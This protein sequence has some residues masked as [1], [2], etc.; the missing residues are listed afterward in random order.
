[1]AT[2]RSKAFY[3]RVALLLALLAGVCV[4]AVKEL[5][6]RRERVEWNR[7]LDVALI[8][9]EKDPIDPSSVDAF[10]DRAYTLREQM[11]TEM[12]RYKPNAPAPF[13]FTIFGPVPATSTPPHPDSDGFIDLT[14]QAWS[15]W[16]WTSDVDE[17]ANVLTKAFDTRIYLVVRK[18]TSG[19]RTVVDGQ[20][21][22]NGR[23]GTVEVELGPD[24][25]DWSLLVAAH[26]LAHTLGATDRY[27]GQNRKE[28]MSP[29][30]L[31][32]RASDPIRIEDLVV[33]PVTA[34]EIGWAQ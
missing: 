17:R 9:V 24:A 2:A 32:L 13:A 33:G 26:E 15:M 28:L 19:T 5:R 10:R 4:Y 11:T 14:E 3:V 31:T 16:R 34:R 27:E 23:V 25:I 12:H 18:A 29:G 6:S 1:M 30:G 22:E 7:T 21:E 20:S 8:L